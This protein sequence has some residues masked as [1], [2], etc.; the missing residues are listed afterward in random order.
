MLVDQDAILQHVASWGDRFPHAPNTQQTAVGVK[1]GIVAG[2]SICLSA[3]VPPP[4]H[5]VK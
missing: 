4:H 1:T 5:I 3:V 2:N